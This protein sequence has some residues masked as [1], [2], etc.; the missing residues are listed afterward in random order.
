[1]VTICSIVMDGIGTK[2]RLRADMTF[3]LALNI[4][5]VMIWMRHLSSPSFCNRCFQSTAAC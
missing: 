2:L 5:L 3:F 4:E 1:M